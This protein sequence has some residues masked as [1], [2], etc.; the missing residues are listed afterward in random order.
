MSASWQLQPQTFKFSFTGQNAIEASMSDVQAG[1]KRAVD[2]N[3][4]KAVQV[5]GLSVA[6]LLLCLPLFSQSNTGRISGAVTDQT[7]GAIAGAMVTPRRRTTGTSFS[8]SPARVHSLTVPFPLRYSRRNAA[9]SS[10]RRSLSGPRVW[11]ACRPQ[12]ARSRGCASRGTVGSRIW[13]RRSAP[14]PPH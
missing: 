7:G 2:L 3:I 13:S 1:L 8:L 4:A 9:V 10:S 6:A 11:P 14:H 12:R 5:L